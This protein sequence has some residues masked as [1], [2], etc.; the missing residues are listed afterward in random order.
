MT[1][2]EQLRG[3][4]LAGVAVAGDHCGL[5]L[6]VRE[7]IAAW[8]DRFSAGAAT[9]APVAARERP[10]GAPLAAGALHASLV[11]VLASIALSNGGEGSR[12]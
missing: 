8:M 6:L 4:V 12:R 9:A 5:V 7:G 3:H 10:M 1:A 11:R 2:Y